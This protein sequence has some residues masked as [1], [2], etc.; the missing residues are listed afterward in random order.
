MKLI[1]VRGRTIQFTL[2]NG[3]G[4]QRC[5]KYRF[6]SSNSKQIITDLFLPQHEKIEGNREGR[7]YGIGDRKHNLKGYKFVGERKKRCYPY[8]I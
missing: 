8:T 1:A 2:E 7:A 3:Q 6:A 4:R 5:T